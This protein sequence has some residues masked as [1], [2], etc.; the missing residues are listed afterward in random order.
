MWYGVLGGKEILQRTFKNLD[1]R[2]QLEC[3]GQKIP[4]PSLQGIVI[5]NFPSYMGGANFWGGTRE[6]DTFQAPSFD[7]KILEVVAVFGGMQMAVSRVLDIQ[8]HRIAQSRTVKITI[9][10]DEAVPVQVDGEAWNQPPGYIRIVHKNRAQMLTRD[11]AFEKTLTQWSEKQKTE[12]PRSPQA[13]PLSEEE[14]IVLQ[15]FVEAASSLIK[16]VKVVSR[17]YSAVEE[18]LYPLTTQ[19]SEFLDNLFPSGRLADL[20]TDETEISQPTVRS[21]VTD[22]IRRVQHLYNDT[23]VFLTDK[24]ALLT[25]TSSIWWCSRFRGKFRCR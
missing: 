10:G 20:D 22:F 8:H 21:Q 4:L 6:K 17:K 15:S 12:R 24:A 7:D 18:D 5:L 1:Q 2:V 23:N 25:C 9:I 11:R 14:S 3:D 16:C 19:S 13:I